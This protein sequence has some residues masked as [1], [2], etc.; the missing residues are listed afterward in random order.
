MQNA[1]M[2]LY[3]LFWGTIAGGVWTAVSRG[4]VQ[5]GI[6]GYGLKSVLFFFAGI[7][8]TASAIKLWLGEAGSTLPES[9]WDGEGRTYLHY[10]I[11]FVVVAA[12]VIVL[13]KDGC[14]DRAHIISCIFLISVM[15]P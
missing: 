2:I 8:F 7:Y 3:I 6:A 13:I 1:G 10:G 12:A 5:D 15:E 14:R 9:F 11:V 4:S